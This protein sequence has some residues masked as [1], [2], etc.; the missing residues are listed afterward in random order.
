MQARDHNRLQFAAAAEVERSTPG[1]LSS[2]VSSSS[3]LATYELGR[4]ECSPTNGRLPRPGGL[5]TAARRACL[6]N[7][8]TTIKRRRGLR[9]AKTKS[10]SPL[11]LMLARR[12]APVRRL[13]RVTGR[14]IDGLLDSFGNLVRDLGRAMREASPAQSIGL[15]GARKMDAGQ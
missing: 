6:C 13:A 15:R 5:A 1:Q 4:G 7:L 9:A 3:L 14:V 11:Q 8:L 10:P 12:L 2:P